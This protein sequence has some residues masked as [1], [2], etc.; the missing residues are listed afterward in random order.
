[1]R[2]L[3]EL[4]VLAL[5]VPPLCTAA[6]WDEQEEHVSEFW[7]H[8][9]ERWTPTSRIIDVSNAGVEASSNPERC[10]SFPAVLCP[11]LAMVEDQ[12]CRA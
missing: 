2:D 4:L 1:M 3:L 10:G 7:G 5:V 11:A 8:R 9:G 12:E 6:A